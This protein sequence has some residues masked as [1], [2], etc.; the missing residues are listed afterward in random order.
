MTLAW[1]LVITVKTHKGM[2][3]SIQ[4]FFNNNRHC[5][6]ITTL[7]KRSLYKHSVKIAHFVR[8]EDYFYLIQGR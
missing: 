8:F 5:E 4:H 2:M 3:M 1:Y 7:A 6:C